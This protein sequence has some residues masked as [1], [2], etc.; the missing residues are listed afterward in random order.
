MRKQRG[1]TLIEILLWSA[2][3]AAAIVAAF[4]F[5]KRVRVSAAVETEQRQVEQVIK[6][7]NGLF[8][9]QPN[10]SALGEDGAA[11]LDQRGATR[12]GLK[13]VPDASGAPSLATGLGDGRV[14]LSVWDVTQPSGPTIANGGY[15]LA[16]PGLSAYECVRLASA[17]ASNA[18]QVSVGFNALED[19][20]SVV[21]SHRYNKTLGGADVIAN[22]CARPDRVVFLYFAPARSIS[23]G[24]AGPG[25][26]PSTRC[27]PIQEKQYAACPPGQMGTIIQARDGT[28]TGPGNTLVWTAWSTIDSSCQSEPTPLPTITPPTTPDDCALITATRVQACPMGQTGHILEGSVRDTCAGTQTPWT[29]LPPPAGNTCQTSPVATCVPSAEREVV[30]CPAGQG[31]QIVRERYSTC[32]SPQAL[33]VWPAWSA[34]HVISNTCTANCG[35]S[36]TSIMGNTCCTPVPEERDA[37][38]PAGTYGPG[39]KEVRFQ[40][41][42]NATTQSSTWSAWQ[43]YRDLGGSGTCD[44][45]PATAQETEQQWDPRSETCPAGQ[46]GAITYQAEQ[47]RTRDVSYACPAGTTALPT[48]SVGSWTGWVDTG[49]RQNTVNTC[50]STSTCST[51][52]NYYSHLLDANDP[53]LDPAG[54]TYSCGDPTVWHTTCSAGDVC[55]AQSRPGA[56]GSGWNSWDEWDMVCTGTCNVPPSSGCQSGQIGSDVLSAANWWCP[57]YNTSPSDWALNRPALFGADDI[58]IATT[59]DDPKVTWD[60]GGGTVITGWQTMPKSSWSSCGMPAADAMVDIGDFWHATTYQRTTSTPL[61][62]ECG[63]ST[64]PVQCAVPAGTVFNWTVGGNACTFTQASA[65]SVAVSSDHAVTDS[66]APTTGAASFACSAGGVLA[67]TPNAGATCSTSAAC[68]PPTGALDGQWVLTST[69]QID[70]YGGA[71]GN[72]ETNIGDVTRRNSTAAALGGTGPWTTTP[73]MGIGC[74]ATNNGGGGTSARPMLPPSGACIVGER[75]ASRVWGPGHSTG[76]VSFNPGETFFF[77]C[78]AAPP[79]TYN[80]QCNQISRPTSWGCGE[81]RLVSGSWVAT[82][83]SVTID[84]SLN[85]GWLGNGT[86]GT[87]CIYGYTDVLDANGYPTPLSAA[88]QAKIVYD[89]VAPAPDDLAVFYQNGSNGSWVGNVAYGHVYARNSPP[90]AIRGTRCAWTKFEFMNN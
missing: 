28:C 83:N 75:I 19:A 33:P 44:T 24:V 23:A 35:V 20:S 54:T 78:Q 15:R 34:S 32:A 88:D 73:F 43:P 37:P 68:T 67:S 38:C 58:Y 89:F 49:A 39:G 40:G 16:Y 45:C 6:T 87:R 26:P 46:T 1:I 72:I 74:Y 66:T 70:P 82:P 57:G 55:S 85:G 30:G 4:A 86:V 21:V 50:A 18:H 47:V 27:N 7:V 76:S 79:P 51:T 60:D 17:L 84:D 29:V 25:G 42:V 69:S 9:L 56:G 10:F 52:T 63:T 65:T 14:V 3:V 31:G 64:P 71:P 5:S 13:M 81:Y 36:S 59:N 41:C 8:A 48:P 61:P 90:A 22:V 11:Y 12:S 62:A 2:L 77:T 80:G 53:S